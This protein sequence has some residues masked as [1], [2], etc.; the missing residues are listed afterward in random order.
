MAM[1][2]NSHVKGTTT[3]D[4]ILY[5]YLHFKGEEQ[6]KTTWLQMFGSYGVLTSDECPSAVYSKLTKST[7]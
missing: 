7:K 6:G 4:Y 1:A 5:W 2:E 3:H